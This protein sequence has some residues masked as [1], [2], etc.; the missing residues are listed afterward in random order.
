MIKIDPS[1]LDDLQRLVVPLMPVTSGTLDTERAFFGTTTNFGAV[2][3][4]IA[5]VLFPDVRDRSVKSI[6]RRFRHSSM[7]L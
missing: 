4:G 6:A 1:D 7:E 3:P 5:E 2:E